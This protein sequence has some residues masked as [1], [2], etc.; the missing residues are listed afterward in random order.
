MRRVRYHNHGGPEVLA[1]E[2]TGIPRP[3]PG[4]VLI[5]A[6][7][8]GLNYVDVQLRRETSPESVWFRPLPG[9][10]TG[11]VVGTVEAAGPGADPGLVGTRVAAL[12]EDACADYVVA[13]TD[14]LVSVPDELDGGA[15]SMLPL[16]GPV[17]LGVL[18]AGQLAVGGTVLV[19]AGAGTIGHLA[20]QLAR[21]LGAGTVLATASSPAK[22]DFL[23]E[24]GADHAIDYTQPGWADDVRAAA[25]G[26]VGLALD[27][28]G[29]QA[30]HA[31]LDL[32]APH[33]RL[34]VYGASAGT[35][36]DVPVR[37]LY[38]LKTVTG[39]SLLAWRAADPDQARSAIAE[40]TRLFQAGKL[41][42]AIAGRL[43]LTD[44]AKAHELLEDRAVTGRLL[45]V[46]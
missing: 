23:L 6:E 34:V 21:Q 42:A 28:V 29:G 11:D 7:T 5:R 30:L 10:L 9:T 15:A 38:A 45:L 8:I 35:F 26:G 18:R 27:A 44:I 2:E 25:P 13:G 17:A 43:P 24:L 19:T 1:I 32:L 36:A 33:G 31:C 12:L 14:W 37:S 16:T 40:L 4:Q 39:F 3:G 46:P 20:V 41:R 22:R